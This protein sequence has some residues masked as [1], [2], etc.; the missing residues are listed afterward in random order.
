MST[1]VQAA[2]EIRP[3]HV[4]IPEEELEDLRRRIAATLGP[5]GSRSAEHGLTMHLGSPHG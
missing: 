4:K 5:R 3:L 1:T 2:T